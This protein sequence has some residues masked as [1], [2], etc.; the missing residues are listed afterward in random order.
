MVG[1]TAQSRSLD[2]RFPHQ[3]RENAAIFNEAME[4]YAE[5]RSMDVS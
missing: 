4:K 2:E 5:K 3:A 1:L